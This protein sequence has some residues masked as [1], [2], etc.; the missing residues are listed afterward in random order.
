MSFIENIT[1]IFS[2][3]T[4]VAALLGVVLM[5]MVLIRVKKIKLNTRVVT[6]VG[7]AL[8]LGVILKMLRVYHFP[9]GGSVTPGSMV[10]M[11]LI[12]LLYGPELGF[13]TGFLYGILTLIMDPFILHPVQVLFDYPLPFMAL[14]LAGYFRDKKVLGSIV[15]IFGRFL[16]H[17]ISGVVFFGSYAP[18]G[19]S[20]IVYSLTVNGLLIGV[21]GL[22][23]VVIISVL[24]VK[25]LNS[26]LIREESTVKS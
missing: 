14:G 16:A 3:P 23:C 17:F 18:E 21:E 22:I 12:S 11:L 15:S 1:E 24:P 4:S 19:M 13:L 8:A 2:H 26:M 6:H 9:Q 20:P 10:P 5:I 7:I 25:Q